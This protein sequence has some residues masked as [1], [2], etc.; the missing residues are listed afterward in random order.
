MSRFTHCSGQY[1]QI[2]DARLYF[3]VVGDP[4]GK[5]LVLLHGGLGTLTDFN[6]ILDKLPK[7]FHFIGID[8]RGHGK[9][10]LGSAPLTYRQY[11]EDVERILDHLGVRSCALLGFSDGGIV[12]YRIAAKTPAKIEALVTIGAEWKLEADGPVFEMLDGLTAD[13]WIEMFPDSVEYYKAV[14]PAPDFD[15]LVK[16]VAALWTDQTTTGYPDAEIVGITAPSLIV[17]GDGDHLFSLNEAVELCERIEGASFF[18]VPF[19]GHEVHKDAPELF[20]AVVNSFLLQPR[21]VRHEA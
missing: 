21:K 2:G 18:N 17:R 19:A 15:A 7:Q 5:P 12:A 8:F 13:M 11:Q 9:S 20:L 14:N 10:T 16:A 4:A 1:L 3:E 6:A